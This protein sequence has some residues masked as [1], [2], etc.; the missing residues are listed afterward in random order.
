MHHE[1][2][3]IHLY[4]P[5]SGATDASSSQTTP[6]LTSFEAAAQRL[7]SFLPM[8]LL[9]PDGSFAWAGK[10]HQ[11][12]GMIYDA[13]SVIQYVEFRGHCDREQ[14]KTLVKTLSGTDKIDDFAV[15]MLPERQ[16][17]NFQFFE[18]L[19]PEAESDASKPAGS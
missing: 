12:V 3:H 5:H 10:N 2:F 4:G 16:W 9:E 15:M 6:I 8:V 14:M 7:I 11:V 18:R 1:T 19:L 17:K 13:E